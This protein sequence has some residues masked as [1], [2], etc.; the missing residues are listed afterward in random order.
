MLAPEVMVAVA[1]DAAD[2][3]HAF[4]SWLPV[5]ARKG[6][7]IDLMRRGEP[8]MSGIMEY[9][10]AQSMIAL[11][12]RGAELVSLA[13][14]PLAELDQNPDRSFVQGLLNRVFERVHH[15]Y[16]FQALYEFKAKF[17]PSWEPVH[18]AYRK[19]AEL[20]AIALALARAHLPEFG[21]GMLVATVGRGLADRLWTQAQAMRNAGDSEG[22]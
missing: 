4:A 21:I 6:W 10:I 20:P 5:P 16:D 1:L 14:A 22:D 15:P 11:K 17:Q 7:V 8:A 13:T 12:G 3:V 9:L 2:H 18:L 19:D